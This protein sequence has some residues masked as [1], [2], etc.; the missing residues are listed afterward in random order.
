MGESDMLIVDAQVHIWGANTP[1]RPWPPGRSS[2]HRPQPF[3]KDDLL[4]EMDATGVARVVIVP[5][6]WEGDRNDLALEAARLHPDRFAVM[7]RPPAA[8]RSLSDWRD[9]PGMLGLR[10]TSNTAEAQAL[11]DDP[12]GW[13]WNE[14]ERAGLPVMVSPSGLLPQ[15]DRIAAHHPELKLVID[16]LALLRAKD[17]AAFDDL[18]S[19]CV[20][21]GCPTSRSRPRHRRLIR[22]TITPITIC[23][24]TCA[25]CSTPSARAECFGAPI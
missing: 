15:V 7:G 24:P 9:Q 18:P 23:T 10:V 21:R 17:N 16:H 25:A 8:A 5:P 6:S 20:W 11:F 3:S 4:K 1:E 22:A 14:A 2:P 13:V 12:A 19:C